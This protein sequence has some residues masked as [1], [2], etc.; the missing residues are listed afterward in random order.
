MYKKNKIAVIVP[1]YNEQGKIGKVVSD[2]KSKSLI[3]D[4]IIVV[5]D[6]SKDNT[7]KEAKQA[8]A[9][10]ITHVVN[11]GAGAAIRTG[12]N[13]ALQ[14]KFDI[15]VTMGGDNQD[16]PVYIEKLVS[17]IVDIGTDFV[18]GSRYKIKGL[19]LKQPF[20][21]R[22]TTMCYSLLFSLAAGRSITDGSN[23]FR[24]FKSAVL[25]RVNINYSSMNRYEM[26]PYLLLKAIKKGF[27]YKEV[28]VPKYWPKGKSYSK[29]IPF[30]SWWSI[31]RPIVYSLLGF[32]IEKR[33]RKMSN[34]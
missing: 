7:E 29:M 24:A 11:K 2:I 33:F 27:R 8:G 17:E 21:R 31:L 5:N 16:D 3:I 12:Y 10:V 14:K 26:E 9:F 18:Q 30:K 15:L 1:A 22:I 32:N 34:N 20:F 23:G 13:Y 6:G 19:V 4:K 25:K 28:G